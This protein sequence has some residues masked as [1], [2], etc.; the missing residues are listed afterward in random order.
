M[1]AR[2]R[3]KIII[4]ELQSEG[5]VNTMELAESLKVS[6]MTIRR[7]LVKFENQ[8]L[9]TLTHGGATINRGALYENNIAIKEEV[10]VQEKRD[11]AKYCVDLINEGDSVFLDGGTT[12]KEIATL[13]L[14]RKNIVVLTN[15][16]HCANTLSYAKGVQLIIVPGEFRERS[17]AF[18]GPLSVE[19]LERF[20]IDVFFLPTEG[21]TADFGASVPNAQDASIKRLMV[22]QAKKVVC[23]ADSSKLGKSYLVNVCSIS[24]IDLLVTDQSADPEVVA[25]MEEEGL[26]IVKVPVLDS[27]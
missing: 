26:N 17:M 22:K 20:K 11:I 13:L 3:Q 18:L 25:E 6:S 1:R 15:S 19:F 14:D 9:V 2:E 8:G 23:V 21:L 12:T 10:M 16:L 4:Q 5:N 27:K 7:D 24:D